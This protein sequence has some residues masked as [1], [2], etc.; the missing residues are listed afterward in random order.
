MFELREAEAGARVSHPMSDVS[1]CPGR[2]RPGMDGLVEHPPQTTCDIG[3]LACG[4]QE[5]CH[6]GL[7]A[8]RP[9]NLTLVPV[10]MAG[11]RRARAASIRAGSGRSFGARPAALADAPATSAA[12]TSRSE[13]ELGHFV[14]VA[15]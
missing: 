11:R 1:N 6:A 9:C 14:P 13:S 10:R 15:N 12:A 2:G 8:S 3:Q 4:I 7:V 5:H